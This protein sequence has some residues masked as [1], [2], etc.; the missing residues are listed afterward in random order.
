MKAATEGG[1][2]AEDASDSKGTTILAPGPRGEPVSTPASAN[3]LIC[4]VPADIAALRRENADLSRAWRH[5]LRRMLGG[6]IATGYR[7]TAFTKAG[8]YVPTRA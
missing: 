3:V 6:T 1:S 7:V 8:S 4:T 2:P 5:A